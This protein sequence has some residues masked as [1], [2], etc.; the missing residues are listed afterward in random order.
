MITKGDLFDMLLLGRVKA[1][2]QTFGG[3]TKKTSTWKPQKA[4]EVW[5]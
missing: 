5:H 4:M 1:C 2:I 3:E